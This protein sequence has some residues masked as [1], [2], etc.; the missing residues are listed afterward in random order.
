MLIAQFSVLKELRSEQAAHPATHAELRR[1]FNRALP[2]LERSQLAW[3]HEARSKS[4]YFE[5]L[6]KDHAERNLHMSP[7]D[8]DE[9]DDYFCQLAGL[10]V[11][12][13]QESDTSDEW[14]E[15]LSRK[16]SMASSSAIAR[17]LAQ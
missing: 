15:A 1:S 14:L 7:S 13:M 17:M 4:A 6:I 8:L 10:F 12:S 9:F 3:R 2:L 11:V 16:L 5:T